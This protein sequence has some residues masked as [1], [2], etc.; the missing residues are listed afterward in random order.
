ML[1]E[2]CYTC[3]AC[4][5]YH[6]PMSMTCEQQVSHY[7]A[8]HGTAEAR[9]QWQGRQ[10]TLSR[11]M[12]ARSGLE[13]WSACS[14][15]LSRSRKQATL[16]NALSN[17]EDSDD[18]FGSSI[19]SDGRRRRTAYQAMMKDACFRTEDNIVSEMFGTNIPRAMISLSRPSSL[20]LRL[21][22]FMLPGT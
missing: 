9:D 21:S 20:S 8:C 19:Q 16:E 14:L 7:P 4:K 11:T 22:R 15:K 3:P 6:V 12:G 2:L 18:S 10:E 1:Q 13:I 17:S 5:R